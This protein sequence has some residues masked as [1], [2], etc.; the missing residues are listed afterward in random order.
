MASKFLLGFGD[1]D[2]ARLG[3]LAGMVPLSCPHTPPHG[4]SLT[5]APGPGRNCPRGCARRA[6]SASPWNTGEVHGH[7]SPPAP[8]LHAGHPR[9][10][11]PL[12]LSEAGAPLRL[13]AAPTSPLP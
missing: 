11:L 1:W 8:S 2:G 4:P 13:D 7:Q 9:Q 3:T 6:T 12:T 10:H 5:H